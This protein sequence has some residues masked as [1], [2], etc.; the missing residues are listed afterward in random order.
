VLE[1]FTLGAAA[2]AEMARVRQGPDADVVAGDVVYTAII[3]L[4]SQP[5]G[6]RWGM[7]AQVDIPS[8]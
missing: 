1:L 5:P 6:L 8:E 2:R 3:D 4:D 7:S